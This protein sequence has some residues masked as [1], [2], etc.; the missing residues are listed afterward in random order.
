MSN[1]EIVICDQCKGAGCTEGRELAD[2]HKHEYHYFDILC[3]RCNG[4]GR[5]QKTTTVDY[6]PY[7]NPKVANLTFEKLKD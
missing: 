7:D 3:T 5:L 6:Q 4:S 1:K 2:Y